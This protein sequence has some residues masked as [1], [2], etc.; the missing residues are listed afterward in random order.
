MSRSDKNPTQPLTRVGGFF[1]VLNIDFFIIY[2]IIENGKEG[3]LC[4]H[5]R[6]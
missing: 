3:V 6:S 2:G 1:N 4:Y 5:I